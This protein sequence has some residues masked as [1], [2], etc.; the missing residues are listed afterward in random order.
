MLGPC[1]LYDA[2]RAQGG[3]V[4]RIEE[5]EGVRDRLERLHLIRRPQGEQGRGEQ[6]SLSEASTEGATPA[7]DTVDLGAGMS[8]TQKLEDSHRV[9]PWQV[10]G[11]LQSQHLMVYHIVGP[12]EVVRSQYE[13]CSG[14]NVR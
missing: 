2:S 7:S 9:I 3:G 4:V 12:G 8:L 1:L 6:G 13:P 14:L 5:E 10:A 11:H